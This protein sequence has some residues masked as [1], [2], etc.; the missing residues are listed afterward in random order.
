MTAAEPL[1]Q[2]VQLNCDIADSR[3]AGDYTLCV[4][5]LKMREFYRWEQGL[6]FGDPLP[7]PQVGAWLSQRESYWDSLT[8]R[9]F[10]PVPVAGQDFDPFDTEA[11]NQQLVPDGLVYSAGLG[12]NAR[13]HF[14]C[15]ELLRM[16]QHRDYTLY[17]AGRELARDLTAPPAMSQG[18]RIFIRRES[19]RRMLWERIEE[20]SWRKQGTAMAEALAC[21][22]FEG[23]ATAVLERMTDHEVEAVVRHELGEVEAGH[24]LGDDWERMLA[25]LPRRSELVARAVRD[26]LA[27][28]LSTLPHL[29]AEADA[30]SLHFYFAGFKGMRRELFPSLLEA[31]EHW[32]ARGDLAPLARMAAAGREHW[33]GVAR[34][35][36]QQFQDSR[37]D[38]D[39]ALAD[40]AQSKSL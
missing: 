17:V 2:A 31:Y 13:P 36:L 5:L 39:Q 1:A 37:Q 28:C 14:F 32:R 35:M 40:Y 15:G 4:Y 8:E 18:R 3:F 30:A 21:H 23:D 10:V 29:V 20:W 16:E 11:I 33:L 12:H 26:N 19:L 27:D 34:N 6:D 38:L 22:G 9:E 25:V 7:G 24:L